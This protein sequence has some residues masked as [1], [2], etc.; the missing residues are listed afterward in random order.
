MLDQ[1]EYRR[2]IDLYEQCIEINLALQNQ[3]E[4]GSDLVNLAIAYMMLPSDSAEIFFLK[5]L[6][7]LQGSGNTGGLMAAKFN[8]ANYLKN[9]GKIEAARNVYREVLETCTHQNILK[10]K[11][12]ANN[13][14]GRIAAMQKDQSRASFHFSEA[15]RLARE[16]KQTADLIALYKE[17]F[18]GFLELQ[19]VSNAR[20]YFVLWEHLRDSTM[21]IAR[22]EA[23]IRYQ[24]LYESEKIS[25]KNELL[26]HELR[27]N[28]LYKL[29][30]LIIALLFI[31]STV[32][33][34][35]YI[36]AGN[37]ETRL[38]IEHYRQR[39]ATHS[40]TTTT[41]KP[42]GSTMNKHEDECILEE[43][44]QRIVQDRLFCQPDLTA[45]K[46]SELLGISR[47][48]LSS[49]LHEHLQMNFNG[50]LNY[51]RIEEAKR[52]LLLPENSKYTIESIGQK[53]GFST[54][55][56]FYVIFR[57]YTGLTP[58]AYRKRKS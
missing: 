20:Q 25:K 31:F 41:P 19:D 17:A 48:R 47:K 15:I 54:R 13:Q 30:Y 22:D 9:Q 26:E 50:L 18:E 36:R 35:M 4:A 58:V 56:T 2:A 45:D 10:G 7:I 37:R 39:L 33:L 21:K 3:M 1:K 43:L 24:T 49:I 53:V 52:E 27:E 51:Y 28:D 55:Q 38:L 29:I 8:Y 23:V 44:H 32:G 46:L 40:S 14:L 11:I 42:A 5:A 12:Y 6:R 16:N 57:Q 34:I